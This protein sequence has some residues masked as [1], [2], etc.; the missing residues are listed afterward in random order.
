MV[1]LEEVED[2]YFNNEQVG[3]TDDEDWDTDSESDASSTVSSVE[4][5]SLFERLSALQDIIPPKQR[6]FLS[7]TFETTS[8]WLKSGLSVGGNTLW[9]LSSSVILLGVP[10]VMAFAD[11]QQIME[12]EKEYNLQQSANDVLV[13]GGQSTQTSEAL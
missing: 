13:S 2:E 9:V 12:A 7:S 8:S 3:P 11:D 4:D 1:K 10:W 5:E 6:R